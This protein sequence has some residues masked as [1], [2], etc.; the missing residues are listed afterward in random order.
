[1]LS[2]RIQKSATFCVAISSEGVETPFGFEPHQKFGI[3]SPMTAL[4]SS[5]TSTKSSFVWEEPE[6]FSNFSGQPG[7][8]ESAGSTE[9]FVY[10]RDGQTCDG[11]DFIS[12]HSIRVL[13]QKDQQRF[14][15][16]LAPQICVER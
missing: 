14:A 11:S 6:L 13:E 9:G 4:P 7:L 12:L 5:I 2:R 10:L 3:D 1:M 15:F 16:K 8:A